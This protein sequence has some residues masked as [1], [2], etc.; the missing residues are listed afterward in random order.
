MLDMGTTGSVIRKLE[1]P[2]FS[3]RANREGAAKGLW[4]CKLQRDHSTH[5]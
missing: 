4:V 5:V 2:S 1:R 3:T